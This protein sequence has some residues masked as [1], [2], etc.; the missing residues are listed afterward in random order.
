VSETEGSSKKWYEIGSDAIRWFISEF[1]AFII[2]LAIIIPFVVLTYVLLVHLERMDYFKETAA[3][4]GAWV[5]IVIGY[6]FGS[7]K[8]ENLTNEVE[9][10]MKEIDI[11][12]DEYDE[13][14]Q[15]LDDKKEKLEEQYAK[16]K[17][18]LQY[19][20]GRYSQHLDEDLL[21]RLKN[22]HGI[23]I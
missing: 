10:L 6:F 18:E 20:V 12:T 19:I 5:G 11:T 13:D 9:E 16:S 22:D 2:A 17:F 4:Y 1:G 8:V 3:V 23:I 14:Y 21:Q 15:E 7:R